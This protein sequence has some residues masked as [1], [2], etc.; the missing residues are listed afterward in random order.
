MYVYIYTYIYIY[1]YI[2]TLIPPRST[3][4]VC[5]CVYVY[6]YVCMPGWRVYSPDLHI[7]CGSSHAHAIFIPAK[8]AANAVSCDYAAAEIIS[9]C[10]KN[11]CMVS[12]PCIDPSSIHAAGVCMCM[13]VYMYVCVH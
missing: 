8:V 4:L 1:I 5:V 11:T 7:S 6:A 13:C 9:T 2:Y 10:M 12:M 3:P